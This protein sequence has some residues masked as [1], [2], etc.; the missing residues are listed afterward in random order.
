MV[1]LALYSDQVIPENSAM[2]YRLVELIKTKRAGTRV[3]YLPSGPEPD[4]RYYL[5]RK[6]Y[7]AKYGLDLIWFCD[8]NEPLSG[9]HL[10]ELFD[11]DAIHLS[12]GH[13]GN[14]LKRLRDS[15]MFD[16][17]RTWAL[18]GEILVGTSAGAILLTPTIAIDTLFSGGKPEEVTDGDALNLLPFEFFPHLNASARYVTELTRYSQH[19]GR[20][21][22][23]VNDG[24]G[25]IISD[26]VVDCIGNPVWIFEGAIKQANEIKLDGI[27][28]SQNPKARL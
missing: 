12:G 21:I 5:N 6:S 16:L 10:A 13:T 3:A 11:C 4:R 17:L 8:L 27:T 25:V 9:Q 26:G 2:D 1:N 22:I 28:I 20:P 19:N 24:D 23:A 14:F 18:R 7:Y 15:G